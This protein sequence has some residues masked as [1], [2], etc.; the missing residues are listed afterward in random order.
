MQSPFHNT[1][2][3]VQRASRIISG[4]FVGLLMLLDA[5][6]AVGWKTGE[7]QT[8]IIEPVKTLHAQSLM[9]KER[10]EE[11]VFVAKRK[12]AID[13][14]NEADTAKTNGTKTTTTT[15]N[16]Y[17]NSTPTPNQQPTYTYSAP[18][19]KKTDYNPPAWF[20]ESSTKSHAEFEANAAQKSQEFENYAAKSK[21]DFEAAK[22]AAG[23]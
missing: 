4:M 20:V 8:R 5:I 19:L 22:A 16:T 18:E 14:E 3:S 7:I 12:K 17:S 9:Q 1:D 23:L 15:V 10:E 13:A 21:A 6:I 2:K 11:A